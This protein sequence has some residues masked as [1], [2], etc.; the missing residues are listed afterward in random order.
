MSREERLILGEN[1]RK[2]LKIVYLTIFT[3]GLGFE[4]RRLIM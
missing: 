4:L 2:I 3:G 1:Q